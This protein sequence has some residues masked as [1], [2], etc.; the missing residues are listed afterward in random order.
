MN[1]SNSDRG[2]GDIG[3][4]DWER[5]ARYVTGEAVAN[6]A[7]T[8]RRWIDADPHRGDVVRLLESVLAS[9]ADDNSD[10]DVE[11]A[12]SAVKTR[13]HEPK[14]LPFAARPV[15]DARSRR[16]IYALARV[17]A[18]VLIIVGGVTFWENLRRS[19]LESSEHTYA[20][21]IGE[22]RQVVLQDGTKVLLG[23]TSRL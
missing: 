12:L 9:G 10:V 21:G 8:T 3:H 22:R 13:M 23:P 18:A 11:G 2:S 15:G 20:T 5:I 6:E 16:T 14:V 19:R 4:D 17:A 1:M 7:E